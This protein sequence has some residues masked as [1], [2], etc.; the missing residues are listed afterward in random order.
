[1]PCAGPLPSAMGLGASAAARTPGAKMIGSYSHRDRNDPGQRAAARAS[2]AP[3][4]ECP[5]PWTRR[6]VARRSERNAAA[7]SSP[8]L[9]QDRLAPAGVSLTP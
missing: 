5:M 8:M 7:A 3:P 4:R 6:P 1:M 2:A 9:D